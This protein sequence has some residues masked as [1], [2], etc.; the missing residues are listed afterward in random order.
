MRQN[1]APWDRGVRLIIAAVFFFLVFGAYAHGILGWVLG[2]IGLIFMFTG[3]L[4][5][6]PLYAIFKYSTIRDSSEG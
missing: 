6:C 5:F 3:L 2:I 4:G 1:M